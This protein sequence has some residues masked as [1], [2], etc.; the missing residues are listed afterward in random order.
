MSE[1]S[2]EKNPLLIHIDSEIE[3]KKARLQGLA[4]QVQQA[5]NFL[6]E[7]EPN[8]YA[9]NGALQELEILKTKIS[10]ESKKKE[11]VDEKE[12]IRKEVVG[13]EE[14]KPIPQGT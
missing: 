2:K 10:E 12:V 9:L 6:Q 11:A 3:E 13:K 7:Q 14:E 5:K 8:L 1:T 4:T